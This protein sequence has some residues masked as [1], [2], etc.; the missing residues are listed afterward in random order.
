M[1]AEQA[2]NFVK[3]GIL[4]VRINRS[5]IDCSKPSNPVTHTFLCIV[6]VIYD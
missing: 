4:P 3:W 6:E 1:L 2:I 5:A